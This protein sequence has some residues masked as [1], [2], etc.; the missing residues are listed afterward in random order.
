[1]RPEL[2]LLATLASNV[3]AARPF[4]NEADTGIED[5][6]GDIPQGTLPNISNIVGLPDFEWVARKYL[7]TRNFTY[8]R[9]GAAGE[10]SYRNN[11]EVYRRYTLRPRVMIDISDIESSLPYVMSSSV[12]CW[13]CFS[14]FELP[15]RWISRG[16]NFNN[17]QKYRV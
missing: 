14:P 2:A 1:M 10:Y 6:L 15:R 3:L 16:E 5:A 13:F 9:N 11:L 8:Y 12:S 7:P 17:E 4:L